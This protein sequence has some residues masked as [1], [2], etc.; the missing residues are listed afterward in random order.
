M[1]PC[2]IRTGPWIPFAPGWQRPS[3]KDRL[4]AGRSFEKSSVQDGRTH[5]QYRIQQR[6]PARDRKG[7][8]ARM[9]VLRRRI[10]LSAGPLSRPA[11]AAAGRRS[12][13]LG[14]KKDRPRERRRIRSPGN[15]PPVLFTAGYRAPPFP[16]LRCG[17]IRL[18]RKSFQRW[19]RAGTRRLL[20]PPRPARR[21][22]GGS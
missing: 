14:H 8:R 1:S 13:K 19:N 4:Q 12:R 17:P 18:T 15:S 7:L 9:P 21:D 6:A 5:G 11:R 10:C 22:S 3:G 16:F 20:S 2:S